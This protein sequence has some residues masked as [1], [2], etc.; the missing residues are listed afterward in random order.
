M[1]LI[2]SR[3]EYSL[4]LKKLNDIKDSLFRTLRID[5]VNFSNIRNSVAFNRR[6]LYS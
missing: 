1:F 4:N 6:F 3:C 5:I 2:K